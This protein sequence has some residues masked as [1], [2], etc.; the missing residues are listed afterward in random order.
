MSGTIFYLLNN[1]HFSSLRCTKNFN[2]IRCITMAR[3]IQ[4]QKEE[5]TVVSNS[6][7]AVV[8]ISSYLMPPSSCAAS[9]S[10]ASKSLV[11][12]GASERPGSRMN[13]AA[14]SFDVD[15]ASQVQIMY[16]EYTPTQ[17]MT[18]NTVF[19]QHELR[20]CGSR[21]EQL[22]MF[23]LWHLCVHKSSL[24]SGQP[25]HPSAG[26][27]LTFS[28]PVQN[29][30]HHLDSTTFPK[31]TLY[32]ENL[33]SKIHGRQATLKNHSRTSIARLAE[34]CEQTLHRL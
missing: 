25:C 8:N 18:C 27:Y 1:S 21:A 9:S 16:T 5:E 12:S 24:S 4:E 34:T 26:L 23:E 19:S 11:T 17:C 10:I 30:K 3:R 6:R 31:T 33:F 32:I 28:L 14:C 2:L 29:T 22:K 15:S 7:P 13:V 20:A